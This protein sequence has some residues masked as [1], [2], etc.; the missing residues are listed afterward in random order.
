MLLSTHFN[1]PGH[2]IND[3]L[4]IPGL[5]R[6]QSNRDSV[7]RAREAHLIYKA[8]TLG[9]NGIECVRCH[10]IKNKKLCNGQSQK[11]VIL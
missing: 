5:E 7:R 10:A 8:M 2:S 3:F 6:I 9:P 4:L 1:Q 11:I